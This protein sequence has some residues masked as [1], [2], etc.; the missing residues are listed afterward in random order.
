MYKNRFFRSL[1]GLKAQTIISG[2]VEYSAQATF[3]AFVASAAVGEVGVYNNVTGALIAGDAAVD[4]DTEIFIATKTGPSPNQVQKTT[5]FKVSEL[6]RALRT[7]YAA[8]AVQIATVTGITAAAGKKYTVFILDK[9]MGSEPFESYTYS[10]DATAADT[11]ATI[12]AAPVAQINSTTSIVN[13]NRDLIVTA[14]ATGGGSNVLT[15]TGKD[16]F[17]YFTVLVRDDAADA[18]VAVTQEA[19]IGAGTPNHAR[20]I[21]AAGQIYA[22]VTTNYPEV[23]NPEEFGKPDSLVSDAS[24]YA[25]YELSFER[26]GK[27]VG[28]TSLRQHA[29][30][31]IVILAVSNGAANPDTELKTILGL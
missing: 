15:L 22:G 2:A 29:V 28:P 14:S 25:T 30:N 13:K 6:S 20:M 10:Y 4:A 19:S 12:V 9:S 18:V 8:S 31:D 24:Q 1:S 26:I 16:A 21:E 27:L 23:A 11:A 17:T 5:A 3:P 7:A